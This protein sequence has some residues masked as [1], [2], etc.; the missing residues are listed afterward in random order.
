[1]GVVSGAVLVVHG[2]AKGECR[3]RRELMFFFFFFLFAG[4]FV[5]LVFL[6]VELE[7]NGSRTSSVDPP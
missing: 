3:R 6:G 5:L 2:V 7:L 1:M 4:W